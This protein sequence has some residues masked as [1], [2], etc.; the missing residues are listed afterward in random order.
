MIGSALK[1]ADNLRTTAGLSVLRLRALPAS[2][3]M[4]LMLALPGGHAQQGSN[5]QLPVAP[6]H[7]FPQ[8]DNT[9]FS[10]IDGGNPVQ[11]EKRLRVINSERQKSLIA[12]TNRLLALATELDNEIAKSNTG[13]LTP[14]QI[15]KVAEIEKLAHSVKDKMSMSLRG[16][17]LNMDSSPFMLPLH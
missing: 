10:S 17:T 3:C 13:E 7:G 16:P 8:P 2:L 9:P 14:E 11:A 15:R 6:P 4:A 1:S 5:S 12:D